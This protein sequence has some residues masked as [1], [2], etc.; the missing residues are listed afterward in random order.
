MDR[1]LTGDRPDDVFQYGLLLPHFG[2]QARPDRLTDGLKDVE[3][4]G[5]DSVW[6]RDHVVYHP[7]DHEDPDRTHIDPLV[8]LSAA[9]VLTGLHLG[10]A[11]LIPH[12]HPI[13]AAGMLADLDYL[14]GGGRL[15]VGFGIGNY[16]HEFD[17]VGLGGQDRRVLIQEYVEVMRQLW[18]GDEVSHSGD[19]YRFENVQIRPVP[20]TREAIPVWY[21]GGSAAAVRRAVEYCQGWLPSRIPFSVFEKR[22]ARMR[23]LAEEAETAQPDVGVVPLVVVAETVEAAAACLNLPPLFD[24]TNSIYASALDTPVNTYSGLDGAAIA[25]PPDVVAEQVIR[26]Q[27]AGARH[28]IFDLR[29]TFDTWETSIALVAEE[30]LP[31]VR[32]HW[33]AR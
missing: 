16:D 17:A 8:V 31:R 23:R 2:S 11:T 33:A 12:R 30:V 20:A 15:T 25:G 4:L 5:F 24:A 3:R 32:R 26:F 14:S 13:L 6:V 27:E 22:V 28:F 7:H 21:G 18:G 29:P 9:A 19:H 1:K 10:T